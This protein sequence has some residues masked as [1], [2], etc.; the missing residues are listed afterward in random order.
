MQLNDFLDK[1]K[2]EY[3]E[4]PPTKN[5]VKIE[6]LPQI[7]DT[8]FNDHYDRVVFRVGEIFTTDLKQNSKKDKENLM[9][10]LLDTVGAEWSDV[11]LSAMIYIKG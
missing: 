3:A 7:F 9:D 11:K 8:L 6:Q 10:F 1:I 5:C 4:A 2:L